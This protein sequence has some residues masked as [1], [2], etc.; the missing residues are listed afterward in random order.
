MG[1]YMDFKG[2]DK[3][4]YKNDNVKLIHISLFLE[5]LGIPN[6]PNEFINFEFYNTIPGFKKKLT[7][8]ED[9]AKYNTKTNKIE[10]FKEIISTNFIKQYFHEKSFTYTLFNSI[11]NND[12]LKLIF[13]HEI[14]HYIQHQDFKSQHNLLNNPQNTNISNFICKSLSYNNPE[15]YC[16]LFSNE[17]TQ[18]DS[19][20]RNDTNEHLHRIVTE[21]FADSFAFIIFHQTSDNKQYS[22]QVL[23]QYLNARKK[24]RESTTEYYF[25]DSILTNV[26]SDLKENKNFDSVLDIKNYINQQIENYVPQFIEE[27]L[28]KNDEVS[29]M[30]N[31]RYLGYI[32]KRLQAN[33]INDLYQSLSS[34]GISNHVLFTDNS[35]PRFDFNDK[36]FQLGIKIAES[37]IKDV[38]LSGFSQSVLPEKTT[39]VKNISS[40]RKQFTVNSTKSP[41]NTI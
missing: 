12:F 4:I 24:A 16:K 29:H 33:T 39:S 35:T 5:K 31:Q 25:T 28:K 41:T 2:V 19:K 23:D 27:R 18:P 21:G 15:E 30:M 8:L 36:E 14:G 32:S 7:H 37:F 40:L 3:Q 34:I 22:L 11:E 1:Y 9:C 6:I 26:F 13:I 17:E 38:N 20:S 10:I